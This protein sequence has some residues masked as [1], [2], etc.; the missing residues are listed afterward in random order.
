MWKAN[1]KTTAVLSSWKL[2]FQKHIKCEMLS[3][4]TIGD[5]G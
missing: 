4:E 5:E 2:Y 3:L 1:G